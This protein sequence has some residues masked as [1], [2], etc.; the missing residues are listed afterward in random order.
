VSRSK[1]VA[2]ASPYR[3]VILESPFAAP[4][5]EGV[6]ENIS[7]ARECLRDSLLRG[8]APLASHLLYTQPGVLDDRV[9]EERERGI[10][11]GLAWIDHADA[12][13]VYVD[14]GVSGGMK[15][16]IERAQQAGR[17]VVERRIR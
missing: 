10:A 9:P 13:V 14:R 7:Y 11:A 8:E 17:P 4:T 2:E 15:R 1:E 16:G 12:T 6:E 5:A 3:L